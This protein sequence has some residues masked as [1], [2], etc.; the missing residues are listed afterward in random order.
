M[1]YLFGI[2]LRHTLS[3]VNGLY[4][5]PGPFSL[6]RRAVIE[7]LGGFRFGYQTEDMEMALRIQRAGY[8]I[9]NAPRA[10]V[11]TKV[12]TT[13]PSLIRQRTR[14]ISGFIRNMNYDYRDLIF[15]KRHEALG[16]IVLPLSLLAIASGILMF[17]L[18]ISM[19]IYRAI[20]AYLVHRGIPF[21]FDFFNHLPSL[22]WFY[23]PASFY[24]LIIIAMI[25]ITLFM[26][27]VGKRIS[28]T[29]GPIM[30]GILPYLFVYG[31][32]AP[33][34]LIRATVDVITNKKRGWR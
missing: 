26:I 5:T 24:L 1:E 21:T 27:V 17:V 6:Y 2:A 22:D 19:T 11:Y 4:V 12:P 18:M 8:R 30:R 25:S 20:H 3:S 33:L 34:W 16:M 28:H 10:R 23:L 32:I 29:P 13:I 7:E 14:W 9:E 31:L 15:S